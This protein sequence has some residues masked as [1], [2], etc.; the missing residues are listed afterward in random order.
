MSSASDLEVPAVDPAPAAAAETRVS[1]SATAEYAC[2]GARSE[3]ACWAIT[4]FKAPFYEPISR[5]PVDIVAVID[6][7]GSMSG[8]KIT[9]VRETLLFV[10]EQCKSP[11]CGHVRGGAMLE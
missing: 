8:E 2:Y 6:K 10:I 4:S 1:L 5:A 3:Q 9:L 11:F 7:S